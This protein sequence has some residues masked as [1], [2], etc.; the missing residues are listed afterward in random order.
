M[1]TAKSLG[2][3]DYS[4]LGD[5]IL[6]TNERYKSEFS[7]IYLKSCTHLSHILIILWLYSATR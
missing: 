1:Y 5:E 7:L 2:W 6:Y 4:K 3:K